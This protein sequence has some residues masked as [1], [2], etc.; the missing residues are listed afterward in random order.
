MTTAGAKVSGDDPIPFEKWIEITEAQNAASQQGID[1]GTVLKQYGMTIGDWSN[2]SA[3]W[4]QKFNANAMSMFEEYTRL[5]DK[6]REKFATGSTNA[7]I[8]F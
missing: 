2:V 6:Y 3:W 8:A 4:S 5:S 1:A 7:D